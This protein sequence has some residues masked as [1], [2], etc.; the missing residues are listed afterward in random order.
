M[1]KQKE[2]RDSLL[3][4]II[5]MELDMFQTVREEQPSLCKDMPETFKVMR[6]MTHCVLSNETLESY[7]KDLSQAAA[8]RRNLM[9]EKYAR[10][11]NLIPCLNANPVIDR[12]VQV[13]HRGR[14]EL[15]NKYPQ[16]FRTQSAQ[17]LF[18]YLRSEL[19][20][21]SDQTLELYFK[22]IS[23][24]VKEGRNLVEERYTFLFRI[25][26]YSSIDDWV[27]KRAS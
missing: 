1:I 20:T 10:M 8:N 16:M 11:D 4:R 27:K 3:D 21:Y 19:E 13:E 6:R 24:A 23:D 18:V 25:L 22:D 5:A 2:Q 9:T 7:L 26:G 17:A 12:I 15:A 14:E